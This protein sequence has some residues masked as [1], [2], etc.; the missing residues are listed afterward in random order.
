MLRLYFHKRVVKGV[1]AHGS[2]YLEGAWQNYV[3][4]CFS[5]AVIDIWYGESDTLKQCRSSK[6]T[7]ISDNGLWSSDFARPIDQH[8]KRRANENGYYWAMSTICRQRKPTLPLFLW[9]RLRTKDYYS[10]WQGFW[11]TSPASIWSIDAPSCCRRRASDC[12]N[13]GQRPYVPFAPPTEEPEIM[14]LKLGL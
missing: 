5:R 12:C 14:I 1:K 6:M 3:T 8:Y 9:L 13:S 7:P 10:Q 4:R 11:W 2:G